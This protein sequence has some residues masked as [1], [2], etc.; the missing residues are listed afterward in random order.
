MLDRYV[1]HPRI[2]V[3]EII[4]GVPEITVA[5]VPEG[6]EP[7]YHSIYELKDGKEFWVADFADPDEAKMVESYLNTRDEFQRM[8]AD[9]VNGQRPSVPPTDRRS[10]Y[11]TVPPPGKPGKGRTGKGR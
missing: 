4:N 11:R 3:V 9:A 1:V 2:D 8:K 10:K 7:H 5:P 6:T